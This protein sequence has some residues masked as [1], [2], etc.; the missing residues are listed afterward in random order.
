M[1][2]AGRRRPSP[3]GT[4]ALTQLLGLAT[5][6]VLLVWLTGIASAVLTGHQPPRSGFAET[7][8]IAVRLLG[9]L[10]DPA[11]AWPPA[12]RPRI[13]GPAAFY[14]ILSVLSL[15]AGALVVVLWRLYQRLGGGGLDGGDGASWA[16]RRD[17]RAL[18]VRRDT[19]LTG[20]IVL[21]RTT[22][23][24]TIATPHRQSLLVFGPTLSGKTSSFVIPTLLRWRGPVIATSSK[25]DMLLATLPARRQRGSVW[26][27]DP[28]LAAGLPA[29]RWSPLVGA[30]TWAEAL[31][32]AYWLTQA[33]SVSHTVQNAE[34]WETLA[35]TLLAPL[36]YAAANAPAATMADVLAWANQP[37][38]ADEVLKELDGLQARDP[39]DPGPQL[40]Q[41]A[42]LA[43]VGAEARRRDSIYGTA[44][45]LLDVY[46]YP[47]VADMASGCDIDRDQFLRGFDDHSAPVDNTVFVYSPEHRQE[48][49][50]P[51]IEA[52][53]SWLIRGAE[54]RYALTG[55]ALDPPL[56]LMLDEAG[57]IAPLRQLGTYASSLA[58][59]GCQLVSVFQNLSQI[60]DRY[61]S[62]ATTIVT[63]HLAKVLMAGTTDVELL[64][65]LSHL[66]GKR[67][68]IEESVSYA[69]DG[70]RTSHASIREHELAPIH[71]LVQ[72]RPGQVLALL[73]HCKPVRLHVRPY[74]ETSDLRRFL[75]EAEDTS[76]WP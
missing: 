55:L 61:G 64:N 25:V 6:V 37:E 24:Q 43:C 65:L 39:T 30:S 38:L 68:A 31:D 71:T 16:T 76:R 45:V 49:L 10:S 62:Q 8:A 26:L 13:P 5:A 72:Q 21:G 58:S 3:G 69:A 57:N 14:A 17:L 74:T 36:L 12:D 40:A 2:A 33:A 23:R 50:R 9:N 56:L 4:S 20:R 63:N 66:L 75:P 46:R 44:Q 15:G 28:F 48:Q 7:G 60:R 35:R 54:D 34:F 59:Q 42:L 1:T 67:E 29:A 70:S 19:P 11:G 47:A 52:F 73:S 51:L 41:S 32:M 27:F 18:V 53:V 22:W